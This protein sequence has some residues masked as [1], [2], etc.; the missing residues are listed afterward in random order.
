MT[1]V[2]FKQQAAR[3]AD[4]LATKH[5]LS[6]KHASTLEAIAAVHGARDWNTLRAMNVPGTA[7]T[8]VKPR[9]LAKASEALDY[10]FPP[11]LGMEPGLCEALLALTVTLNGGPAAE[12]K[13]LLDHLLVHQ[14]QR[15]GFAYLDLDGTQ[16]RDH[17]AWGLARVGRADAFRLLAPE[18]P[19]L[20]VEFNPLAG[21]SPD[22]AAN[23]ILQL[24]P[25]S[26]DYPGSAFYREQARTLCTG[27][28][29]AMQEQGLPVDFRTLMQLLV[30]PAE[31]LESLVRPTGSEGSAIVSLGRLLQAYRDRDGELNSRWLK[32]VQGA[33]TGRMAALTQGKPGRV[34]L[35]EGASWTWRQ[36]VEQGQGVYLEPGLGADA[37]RHSRLCLQA[38][39]E[40]LEGGVATDHPP[41]TVF[42]T[43]EGVA[44]L[45]S[46]RLLRL[47]QQANVGLFLA[48]TR[49]QREGREG[50]ALA[51]NV[52]PAMGFG[53]PARLLLEQPAKGQQR[54]ANLTPCSFW[55]A[56]VPTYQPGSPR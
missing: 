5:K 38:L 7:E 10:L 14:C 31:G 30:N 52:E 51:L 20:S 54:T 33:L 1:E 16:S 22:G 6:L 8:V 44:D 50:W 24:W 39:T 17:V 28:V 43:G 46:P 23:V 12:R 41:F 29:G 26:E 25:T 48:D 36:A 55:P 9:S 3:L 15:G 21:L 19:G 27:V 40:V 13:A 49:S 53:Q 35:P 34:Y 4:H 2:L 45:V 32:T 47:A 18:S 11:S 56:T 42:V 37:L